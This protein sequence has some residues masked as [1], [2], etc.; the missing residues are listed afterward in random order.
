M[1]RRR[2]QLPA[3]FLVLAQ[4]AL[5]KLHASDDEVAAHMPFGSAVGHVFQ[6]KHLRPARLFVL[7]LGAVARGRTA[8]EVVQAL[9]EEEGGRNPGRS[10]P[11]SLSCS[12]SITRPV[13]AVPPALDEGLWFRKQRPRVNPE[14]KV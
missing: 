11:S 5:S 3:Q 10:L 7:G 9:G 8:Q 2:A 4:R 14:T 13:R 1:E 12:S 6:R